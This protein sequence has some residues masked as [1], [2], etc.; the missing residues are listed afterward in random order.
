MSTPHFFADLLRL[1]YKLLAG[2]GALPL[3]PRG[4]G[5]LARGQPGN[6]GFRKVALSRG[7]RTLRRR[8]S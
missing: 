6:L 1:R 4:G 8:L 5:V 2:T 7:L 3:G